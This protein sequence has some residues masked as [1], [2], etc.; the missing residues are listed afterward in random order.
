MKK[1]IAL[2]CSVL[3]LVSL[4]G[5]AGAELAPLGELPLWQGDTQTI[6]VGV[7]KNDNVEDFET[8]SYTKLL[9]EAG[10]VNLD[11]VIFPNVETNTKFSAMIAANEEFPEV[12]NVNIS[13]YI[14]N[15]ID[16]GILLPIDEYLATSS[17]YVKAYMDDPV[18]A[19]ML[20]YFKAYDGN[21]Y[22]IPYIN[23]VI[24]NEWSSRAWINQDWLTKLNLP[25]PTTT[26]EYLE[27]L[28]AFRDTDLNGDGQTSDQYPLLCFVG[29]WNSTPYNFLMGSFIF[30]NA[31]A[32]YLLVDENGKLDTAINK[33]EWKAGL[34]YINQLVSEGLLPE[35]S[36]T[37]DTTA[38]RSIIKQDNKP[39]GSLIVASTSLY[40]E[41]P[42]RED[43]VPLG[44]LVGPEGVQYT[45]PAIAL[46][47]PRWFVTTYAKNPELAFR[48]GDYCWEPTMS[49][50]NRLG[51]PETDWH[52]TSDEEKATM[53]ALYWDMGFEA[54]LVRTTT[55][56][57]PAKR[58][59]ADS[60]PGWRPYEYS[61]PG[62]VWSGDP[63]DYLYTT[64]LGVKLNYQKVPENF[65]LPLVLTGDEATE[66]AEI[67]VTLDAL[68]DEW[69][70]GLSIGT[71]SFDD[72]D[73]YVEELDNA[74]LQRWLEIQQGAYD[75]MNAK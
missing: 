26:E 48:L 57:C 73:L 43:M 16:A 44:P 46:P 6:T 17:V 21:I 38:M 11:F 41:H 63:H 36:F 31:S 67:K 5:S 53:K 65:V 29:G 75:R 55:G 70:A 20:P 52:W 1:S 28:R 4:L 19:D 27:T 49:V 33:P 12:M 68:R 22:G 51:Q 66:A 69:R 35:I 42:N 71:L 24:G 2:V 3:L 50:S 72:W 14:N 58:P 23:K 64:A 25:I 10:N 62:F 34:Q 47:S 13:Q 30:P 60:A 37:Q 7:V 32:D 56:G 59:L 39:V 74:G 45:T 61:D 40:Q 9:E 8:N 18:N 54:M 15:F